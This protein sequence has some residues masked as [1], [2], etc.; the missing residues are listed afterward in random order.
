MGLGQPALVVEVETEGLFFEQI[1]GTSVGQEDAGHTWQ[2]PIP[3]SLPEV[4]QVAPSIGE[5]ALPYWQEN[6]VVGGWTARVVGRGFGLGPI[7]YIISNSSCLPGHLHGGCP[8][9]VM[10]ASGVGLSRTVGVPLAYTAACPSWTH[11]LPLAGSSALPG[12]PNTSSLGSSGTEMGCSDS[13][14][15]PTQACGW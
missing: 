5:E 15:Y 3:F 10:P 2:S 9:P 4:A 14:P 13:V 12:S 1:P 8:A 6:V 11:P 7:H